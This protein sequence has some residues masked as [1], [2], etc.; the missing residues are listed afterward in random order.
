MTHQESPCKIAIIVTL[1]L[2]LEKACSG[3]NWSIGCLVIN[4]AG[5]LQEV[6]TVTSAN[7]HSITIEHV[8]VGDLPEPWRV[9]LQ[10]AN[11]VRVTV[12]IEEESEGAT[13][14]DSA[15][16]LFGMWSDREEMA[17]VDAYMRKVRAPRF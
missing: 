7:T 9:Q 6:F 8:R 1:T 16:P 12:R 5:L 15:N 3:Q 11:N 14:K 4:F 10:A 13:Q 2:N 17:D